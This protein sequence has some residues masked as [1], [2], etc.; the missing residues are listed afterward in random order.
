LVVEGGSAVCVPLDYFPASVLD[1]RW[2]VQDPWRVFVCGELRSQLKP[3]MQHL[4]S[5]L[6]CDLI[7]W[8]SWKAQELAMT[9]GV[10]ATAAEKSQH[11]LYSEVF[12]FTGDTDALRRAL[13][14]APTLAYPL[15]VHPLPAPFPPHHWL[16]ASHCGQ[17]IPA[18][19]QCYRQHI[20]HVLSFGVGWD[21]QDSGFLPWMDQAVILPGE[22]G[23]SLGQ[24]LWPRGDLPP[25][26]GW[27]EVILQ[28]LEA[29]DPQD[30]DED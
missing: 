26:E 4:R 19:L 18:L 13:H 7:G 8:S 30:E 27:N 2:Q 24:S 3:V 25:P 20:G 1:S 29:T 9:L 21:P 14:S 17:G 11:R 23:E 6:Q 16:L 5:Q 15:V 10:T 28:W 22:H 12:A